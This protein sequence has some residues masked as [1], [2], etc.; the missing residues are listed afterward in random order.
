MRST[1]YIDEPETVQGD[2]S[3]GTPGVLLSNLTLPLTNG[4]ASPSESY[5]NIIA[6]CASNND[7]E[8]SDASSLCGG[9]AKVD[10]PA[11]QAN[12]ATSEEMLGNGGLPMLNPQDGISGVFT[13]RPVPTSLD[14]CTEHEWDEDESS[15]GSGRSK[16][17]RG[18]SRTKQ[19]N[20][21]CLE[22]EV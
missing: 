2:T 10:G 14:L 5:L 3:N 4:S 16:F 13:R 7:H 1:S 19:K 11:L 22:T 18:H 17:K 20:V 8:S 6:D 15:E 12:V 9:V 21:H